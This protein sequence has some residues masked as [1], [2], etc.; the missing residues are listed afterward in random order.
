[1]STPVRVR[2]APSPTGHLHIGGVRSALF[3]YLFAKHNNGTFILRTEDTD[4]ERN[5]EGAEEEIL[6]GFRWLG[7]EWEEG[8]D[9]GGP[10][11]P[12]RCTERL[13][14]YTSH[15]VEL[16]KRGLAY[17]CFC[18]PEELNRERED[19]LAKGLMPQYGGTCRHLSQAQREEKLRQGLKPN[20]RLAVPSGLP[21]AFDD[22]IHGAVS[23]SSDDIGDFIIVKSNGIPTYNFQVV[24]DDALMKISHVIRGEEHL[25]NTPR[26]LLVY[27][28]FGF[29][30]PIFAHLPQVLDRTRKKLSKRDPNVMPVHVYR[31]L[32]YLP[33]AIVNFLALLGWSPVGEEELLTMHQLIDMFDLARVNKSGAIFDVDKLDWMATQ[34][35]KRLPLDIA[36]TLVHEQLKQANQTLQN[37]MDYTWLSRVVRLYQEQMSHTRAFI[38]LAKGFFSEDMVMQPDAVATIQDGRAKEVIAAYFELAKQDEAWTADSSRARFKQIQSQLGVKGSAL[39]MP[40]RAAITGVTHGPDLQESV[41]LLPKQWVLDRLQRALAS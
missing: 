14:I 17:P 15:L 22:L 27:H 40:V 28:A 19:A 39:F 20:Y 1:M 10:F 26:Q 9:I 36:T 41:A 34:Y 12:Y 7:F 29:E 11:G 4:L 13:E 24:I 2:Y 18:T 3:N 8:P 5:V 23:F 33:E 32:G 21:L 38:T 31:Q 30:R 25:S 35:M 16:E 6:R 37:N